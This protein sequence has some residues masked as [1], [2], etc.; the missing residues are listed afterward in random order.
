MFWIKICYRNGEG[1]GTRVRVVE[2]NHKIPMIDERTQRRSS[3]QKPP[4]AQPPS[5]RTA[6]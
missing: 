5:K 4:P 2:A 6:P 3:T 1:T